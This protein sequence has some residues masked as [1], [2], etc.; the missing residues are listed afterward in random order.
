[1]K[2]NL[3]LTVTFLT[4]LV[5][6]QDE[7]DQDNFPPECAPACQ[8]LVSTTQRCDDMTEGNIAYSNCVCSSADASSLLLSCGSCIRSNG[9]DADNEA[10]ELAVSCGFAVSGSTGGSTTAK[11]ASATISSLSSTT[12]M[13]TSIASPPTTL[14]TSTGNANVG[15][16]LDASVAAAPLLLLSVFA[17]F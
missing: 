8:S 13:G 11:A 14:P 15:T 16:R 10:I 1:M 5:K 4:L 17:V 7:I 3:L 12:I 9:G 2:L 6:A